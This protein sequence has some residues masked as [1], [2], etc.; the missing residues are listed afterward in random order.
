MDPCATKVT[1]TWALMS[2]DS[3]LTGIKTQ[4]VDGFHSDSYRILPCI[5]QVFNGPA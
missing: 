4:F 1:M 3:I 2:G 5:S